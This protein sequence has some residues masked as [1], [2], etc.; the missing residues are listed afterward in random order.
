MKL[1]QGFPTTSLHYAATA[2][3]LACLAVSASAQQNQPLGSSLVEDWTHHHVIFSNPG[4]EHDAF[5]NGRHEEWR[6]LVNDP[7]YRLQQI[8]RNFA[9]TGQQTN[10]MSSFLEG[11]NDTR[12][13]EMNESTSNSE[14]SIT[15][16]DTTSQGEWAVALSLLTGFG[17]AADMYPAKFTFAPIGT[18]DC[19]NDFVVFAINGAGSAAQA[20]IMGI[21]G[22]YSS[23]CSLLGLPIANVL[24]SYNVGTGSVLTSPV[25]SLNGAKVAFVESIA[26][27]SRFH[28]LTLDKRGSLLTCPILLGPCNGTAYG[29]PA[30]PGVDNVAVDVPITMSGGVNDTDSSPYIDYDNDFAY[31]G[32]DSGKLHKFT[33]VFNGTPTEVTTSPWPLTVVSGTT[34]LRLTGPVYDSVSQK[35]FVGGRD[36][37][38]LYCVTIAG[39]PCS[40]PSVAVGSGIQDAPIVDSTNQTVFVITNNSASTASFVFQANTSLGNT[41]ST[42]IGLNGT[43]LYNGTFDNAYYT[44]PST[45]HYY[46]CGNLTGAATPTLY[47]IGFGTGG[48]MN[49]TNDG[50]TFQ[51]VASGHTGTGTD[52]SPISEIYNVATGQDLL[53]LSV[54]NYGF[55]SGTTNCSVLLVGA[56]PCLMSF[57]VVSGFPTAAS[58]TATSLLGPAGTSGI[59]I[60]NV[61]TT[62][63]ASQIYFG[64][65]QASTGMQLSQA[66]LR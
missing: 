42:T 40:T 7:R 53:F 2:F 23:D 58:A 25:L 45:G 50:N 9:N 4:T 19:T 41:V 44:N 15:Q 52:C 3:F 36:N 61:S 43:D 38:I 46:A 51:L 13:A 21:N 33:G 17:V 35:I 57:N 63:G 59:V 6:R 49:S 54:K 60:D 20:N 24:F 47:R 55:T 48:K 32:D 64:N 18:P 8:R 66:A 27:G 11:Q 56:S 1:T 5:L 16:Q 65:L 29:A 22:L 31:V 34:N 10:S 30:V 62:A 37:G 28:V 12:K 39:A 26:G 14:S